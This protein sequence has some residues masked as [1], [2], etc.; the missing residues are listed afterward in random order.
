MPSVL[1]TQHSI[2]Q[3]LIDSLNNLSRQAEVSLKHNAFQR[4][5]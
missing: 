5:E 3:F 4:L 2:I 1:V